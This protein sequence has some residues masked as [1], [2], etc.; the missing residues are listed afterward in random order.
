MRVAAIYD[1]HGNLPA[2][3]AELQE[4]R[5]AVRSGANRLL[6]TDLRGLSRIILRRVVR[7]NPR[8]PWLI[9]FW[10]VVSRRLAGL[11]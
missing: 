5:A 6:A 10:L 11:P 1:I 8:D 9:L 4:I 7:G 3:E 2:L